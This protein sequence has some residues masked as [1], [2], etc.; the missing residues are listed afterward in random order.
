MSNST[1]SLGIPAETDY[2]LPTRSWFAAYASYL[3]DV[4]RGAVN[5]ID[6][7]YRHLRDVVSYGEKYSLPPEAIL[8]AE[9][10]LSEA[11]E[12]GRGNAAAWLA[13]ARAVREAVRAQEA[14]SLAR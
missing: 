7:D 5:V 9:R 14:R 13:D 8:F 3:I 2:V 12:Q 11:A 4:K 6:I 1:D 10:R